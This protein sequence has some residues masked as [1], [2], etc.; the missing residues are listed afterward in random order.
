MPR[1]LP[2]ILEEIRD[3]ACRYRVRFT[4]KALDELAELEIDIDEQDVCEI[5]A[6]LTAR[7][8]ADRIAAT[9]TGEWMYVFKPRIAGSVLYAKLIVR[10]DCIVISF[11]ED[12]EREL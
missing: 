3:L 2:R 8:F 1:W 4:H 6:T 12:Q 11:H 5:L 7:E 9:R 10:S